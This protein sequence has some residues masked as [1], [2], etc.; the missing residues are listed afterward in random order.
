MKKEKLY[1][2]KQWLEQQSVNEISGI[3]PERL[4]ALLNLDKKEFN[5]FLDFL[6]KE[7]LI[8]KRYRFECVVCGENGIEYEKNILKGR[9]RCGNCGEEITYGEIAKIGHAV[10]E[11]SYDDFM[12]LDMDEIDDVSWSGENIVSINEEKLK[13][14][15]RKQMDN[16][17][18][19]IF[20]GSSQEAKEIMYD[21][22]ALIGAVD[23]FQTITWD[24]SGNGIFV[25]G[26]YT[27]ESL[28]K[29]ADEVDG[30]VFIFN[31]DDEIWYR[32]E[33]Q[34]KTTRDNVIFEYGLF[35]GMK[36]RQKVTFAC[37][38]KPHIATDLMGITYLDAELDEGVLRKKI[39]DWLKR[40]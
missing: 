8:R 29:I 6:L 40:I 4:R 19:K 24:S 34:L 36:G 27:L 31:S 37:K 33:N 11:I 3:E 17:K 23:G 15:E 22:A 13:I 38:N 12:D 14:E 2:I 7:G 21:I 9:C 26:D 1:Q 28:I 32:N 30:A 10:Y 39:R 16:D 35:V 25:P 18:K 20:L 5:H